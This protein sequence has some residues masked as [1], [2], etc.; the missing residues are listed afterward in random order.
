LKTNHK[1]HKVG[2]ILE[3]QRYLSNAPGPFYVANGECISCK[4]PEHAAPT[5]MGYEKAPDGKTGHC[6]FKKQPVGDEETRQAICA[7][8]VACCA[9]LRYAGNHP[10]ILQELGSEQCDRLPKE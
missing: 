3:K 1:D 2:A 9:A 10:A 8:Q 4:A 6:F 5:L 7:V